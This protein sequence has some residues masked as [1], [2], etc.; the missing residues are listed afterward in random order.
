MGDLS[1][2]FSKSEFQCSCGCGF[3]T[4]PGDVSPELLNLLEM[5]R[6]EINRP[7]RLT[8]GCRCEYYNHAVGGVSNSAHTRGTACDIAVQGGSHRRKLVDVAVMFFASGI[9]VA[10]SFIHVDV[11]SEL[12]RPSLWTY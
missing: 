8:S 4:N 10:R 6:E 12:P 9:G 5:M 7:I 3:G 11:D 1:E 2:H